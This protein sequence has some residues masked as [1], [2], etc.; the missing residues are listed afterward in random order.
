MYQNVRNIPRLNAIHTQLQTA[1]EE[2]ADLPVEEGRAP[3]EGFLCPISS[4][5]QNTGVTA[6]W[7]TAAMHPP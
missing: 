6:A 7:W 3:G 5:H 2:P 4:S 1:L